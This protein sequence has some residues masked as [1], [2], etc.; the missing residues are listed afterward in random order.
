MTKNTLLPLWLALPLIAVPVAAQ[1]RLLSSESTV[2][3]ENHGAALAFGDYDG[4]SV[5]GQREVL[6]VGRP[7]TGA[8]AGSVVAVSAL[9]H[10]YTEGLDTIVDSLNGYSTGDRFGAALSTSGDLDGDGVRDLVVG[11]PN[12]R[13][14]H[15][16]S[17]VDLIELSWSPITGSQ[18]S[19][20]TAVAII[21]DADGDGRDDLAVGAPDASLVFVGTAGAVFTYSSA[22]GGQIALVTEPSLQQNARFGASLARVDDLD[23]NAHDEL[24]IGAPGWD[25]PGKVDAGA[26]FV[27]DPFAD[28]YLPALDSQGELT[29]ERHGTSVAAGPVDGDLFDDL[30]VGAPGYAPSLVT[31]PGR[32]R[33]FSGASGAELFDHVGSDDEG[34]GDAVAFGGDMNHDG[35]GEVIGGAPT[36]SGARGR[37]HVWSGRTG[38]MR[39][40][41]EGSSSGD[42]FGRAAAGNATQLGAGDGD[43]YADWAVGAPFVD[44]VIPFSTASQA[45]RCL[46]YSGKPKVLFRGDVALGADVDVIGDATGDGVDDTILASGSFI[47]GTMLIDGVTGVE[48]QIVG[49]S[50]PDISIAGI[51]DVNNDGLA[52]FVAGNPQGGGVAPLVSTGPAAFEFSSAVAIT[53]PA[54]AGFGT[55]VDGIGDISGDGIPDLVIGCPDLPGLFGGPAYGLVYVH[56]GDPSSA[57]P[58]PLLYTV[59]GQNEDERFGY[60][61]AGV[62]DADLDGVPDIAVGAPHYESLVSNVGRVAVLS[63]VDGSQLFEATGPPLVGGSKLGW[64][65]DGLGD[66]DADGYPDLVAGAP[67]YS[68]LGGASSV[69]LARVI[70]APSGVTL[71]SLTGDQGGE[72]LGY[73]VAGCGDVDR[74]GLPDLA[75]GSPFWDEA[76]THQDS[77]RVR[78]ARG[79]DAQSLSYYKEYGA[80][81]SHYGESL[82]GL[83]DT[84]ADGVARLAIGAPNYA[85]VYHTGLAEVM[86]LPLTASKS[87][88]PGSSCGATPNLHLDTFAVPGELLRLF[89]QGNF[90]N[91]AFVSISLPPPAFV[92]YAGCTIYL[93]VSAI[94]ATVQVLTLTGSGEGAVLLPDSTALLGLDLNAQALAVM[95]T[96]FGFSNGRQIEIGYASQ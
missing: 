84:G 63:G 72:Q 74:D 67:G 12:G 54:N 86:K 76:P 24:L 90:T 49:P 16:F 95:P 48:T 65:V 55:D 70:S 41:V 66:V 21:D 20:G 42:E 23:F 80:A 71:A 64:S 52:D 87:L 14:V 30:I 3:S 93:D 82:G 92:P 26:A 31:E 56:S 94:L 60:S 36:W 19:F 62:G 85:T 43:A 46:V 79:Y 37:V 35:F 11:A 50:W 44:T 4:P 73:A 81:G 17:G 38:D 96:G 28:A 9:A 25:G 2:D 5:F 89:I 69:G 27:Y 40:S 53:G 47:F 7:G 58:F 13:R 78:L 59:V 8:G 6:Y 83:R 34:L 15:A 18:V 75:V 10:G 77:G 61:V 1:S 32:V 22:D 39:Y 33:V 45:G 29:G 68:Q 51:G 91:F 57:S 88:S